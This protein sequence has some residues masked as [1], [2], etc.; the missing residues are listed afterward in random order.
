MN[1]LV[2]Q[3]AGGAL[4]FKGTVSEPANV[5]VGGKPATVT[6]DN[7][8]EGQAVVPGGT[9]QVAVTATD[10]SGN[11]RTSTYQVSQGATSKSFT[12]DLNGNMT[13]DGTR[14]YEWDAEN[15]LVA[16]KDGPATVA[17]YTYNKSGLRVSKTA[18]GV[19]TNYV[20]DGPGIVEERLST[21][22]VTKHFQGPSIDSV[23]ALQDGSGTVAYLTRDHLGSI[24]E[25][26]NAAGTTV[27]Q[28]RAY[29][30]WGTVSVSGGTAGGWAFTGR[31]NDSETSLQ[32][33]RARYYSPSVGRFISEDPLG[34]RAGINRFSYVR[35]SPSKL[36]DPLG[37]C[38]Y[39]LIVFNP[40]TGSYGIATH[41]ALFVDH[42]GDPFLYDPS[43]GY[44]PDQNKGTVPWLEG[45]DAS[46]DD[47]ARYHTNL[48]EVVQSMGF[49]TTSGEEDSI[50]NRAKQI[51]DAG[52][53]AGCAANVSR[54]ISGVGPF[55]DVSPT[56][57]PA[58][59]ARQAAKIPP[60]SITEYFPG[61]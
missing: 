4:V 48:G 14:T 38:T 40:V 36:V 27:V 57:W 15:R 31:E 44:V 7:R 39:V 55:K 61:Y 13:S 11:V 45:A 49:C 3:Q 58:I 42:S 56:S 46:K 18:G 52:R 9:G 54:A 43:G 51:G 28:R 41:A 5:T 19:T 30:P 2:S 8:F 34:I 32:Y 10:P 59:L 33:Y 60:A 29:D 47:F 16:V 23:L 26:V 35:N 17:S 20:L 37:L 6:A 22:G 53:P 25:Q 50:V 21:G 1:Q 24:R 12:Y